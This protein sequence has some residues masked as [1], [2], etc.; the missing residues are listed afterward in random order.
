MMCLR[1][2]GYL[3]FVDICRDVQCLDGRMDGHATYTPGDRCTCNVGYG[4]LQW[5]RAELGLLTSLISKGDIL[6]LALA[7]K[8][9]PSLG[10]RG[11][12]RASRRPRAG[13]QG[14]L[15]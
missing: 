8:Y 14:Q 6:F 1:I 9:Q 15:A 10:C 2:Y 7:V 4:C 12:Y 5:T 13:C 3:T 11:A